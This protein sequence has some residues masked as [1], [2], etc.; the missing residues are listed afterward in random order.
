M[1][2]K[3]LQQTTT[4]KGRNNSQLQDLQKQEGS[5]KHFWNISEQITTEHD[6]AKAKGSQRHCFTHVLLHNMLRTEQ[7]PKQMM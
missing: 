4:H 3:S 6:G 7:K 2:G 5:G 1:D